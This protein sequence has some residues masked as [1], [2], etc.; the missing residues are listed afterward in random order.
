MIINQR[1]FYG[2]SPAIESSDSETES[3][4]NDLRQLDIIFKE[5]N[6]FKLAYQI[7]STFVYVRV[8]GITDSS[9][10][11]KVITLNIHTVDSTAHDKALLK[12][13]EQEANSYKPIKKKK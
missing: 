11:V 10:N 1:I 12:L 9:T 2:I 13:A 6:A 3:V 8:L 7:D 5:N 4:T